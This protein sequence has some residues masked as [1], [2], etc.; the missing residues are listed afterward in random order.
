MRSCYRY[1]RVY[2]NT[3]K[4]QGL[5]FRTIRKFMADLTTFNT[6]IFPATFVVFVG[7][8]FVLGLISRVVILRLRHK[9][10]ST[11]LRR[12]V[13]N[14]RLRWT[15][16]ICLGIFWMPPKNLCYHN[17]QSCRKCHDSC[18]KYCLEGACTMVW[19]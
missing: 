6:I 14:L 13:R 8:E 9:A 7:R 1:C 12:F 15:F 3:L 2:N 10:K 4:Q 16:K 17:I 5:R 19:V 18:D 11:E